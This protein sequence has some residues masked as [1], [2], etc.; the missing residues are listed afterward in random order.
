MFISTNTTSEDLKYVSNGDDIQISKDI[1]LNREYLDFLFAN[2][3]YSKITILSGYDEVYSSHRTFYDEQETVILADN[4][5]YIKEKYNKE[6]SFDEEFSVKD[7]IVASRK[8]NNIVKEVNSA[9]VKGKPLSPFE[10]F[11]VAYRIVTERLY[12]EVDEGEPLSHSRSLISVM[13]GDKIVCAGFANL[14]SVVLNRLGIPCTTQC[15]ISY[16]HSRNAYGNHA[17]CLVRM[18]D[19]KYDIDGIYFS[20]PTDDSA[21]QKSVSYGNTS[22]NHALV[23][24]E[25]VK[26]HF[27]KP[28]R[29]NKGLF[30][31]NILTIADAEK[32]S[33]DVEPILADLFPEKTGG[34]SQD[35]LIKEKADQR[36]HELGIY[37]TIEQMINNFSNDQVKND[38]I[39]MAENILNSSRLFF[40]IANGNLNGY[41]TNVVHQLHYSGF[42]NE[43]IVMLFDK[44]YSQTKLEQKFKE[45]YSNKYNSNGSLN[46]N[47]KRKMQREIQSMVIAVQKKKSEVLKLPDNYFKHTL[48]EETCTDRILKKLSSYVVRKQIFN[49]DLFDNSYAGQINYLMLK[50]LSLDEIKA[51]L[52][53]SLETFS[54]GEVYFEETD[55]EDEFS[56][57]SSI[58]EQELYS[59]H[60]FAVGNV[61]NRPYIDDFNKLANSARFIS[62]DDFK[63]AGIQYFLSED[64]DMLSAKHYTKTMLARTK[65]AEPKR[66]D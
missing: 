40:E 12:R 35:V 28:V 43:E 20:N 13:N 49:E 57:F 11:M 18:V 23:R 25:D 2:F 7:A 51:R 32:N 5:N 54:V 14:L 27:K 48:T 31:N 36:M 9:R 26:Y 24:L 22:F 55:E 59:G 34:K 58:N 60:I 46:E 30:Q 1:A 66:K 3:P 41:L 64:F 29:M 42:K 65:I 6:L 38:S 10:K 39:L 33:I 44:F 63:K 8:I 50:G 19:P 17:T 15:M 56:R 53:K 21:V 37:D 16:D 61:F 45:F 4:A 62:Q 52:S 47:T